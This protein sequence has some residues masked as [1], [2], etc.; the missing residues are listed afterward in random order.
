MFLVN[1]SCFLKCIEKKLVK[2]S[3]FG[4]CP[5]FAIVALASMAHMQAHMLMSA[6]EGMKE[7]STTLLMK[8][9]FS[10]GM[11]FHYT[12]DRD[13][14]LRKIVFLINISMTI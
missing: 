11:F 1:Y 5:R 12:Y 7:S 3:Y 13:S 6:I 10:S 9:V 14:L 8:I 2:N 4:N